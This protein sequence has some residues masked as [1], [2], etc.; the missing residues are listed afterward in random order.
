MH[1]A[2]Y[3]GFF[4]TA[5]ISASTWAALPFSSM[6]SQRVSVDMPSIRTLHSCTSPLPMRSALEMS[7]VPP[8]E[9]ESTPPVPRAWV[10]SVRG[11]K[12]VVFADCGI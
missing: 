5:S 9:A 10:L 7:Q 6:F 12:L 1:G 11:R 4:L 8:D 3:A 2:L